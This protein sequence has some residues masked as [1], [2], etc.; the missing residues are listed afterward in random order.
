MTQKK[1]T[2]TIIGAGSLGSVLQQFFSTGP[3]R[4]QSVY[5]SKTGT[6]FTPKG[7][8]NLSASSP[9]SSGEIGDWIFI[10]TP[11]DLISEIAEQ[12]SRIEAP[13]NQK[14][15]IHCSGA[16]FS[17]ELRAVSSLGASVVAM[18]PIQSF[19]HGDSR[20]RLKGIFVTLEGDDKAIEQLTPVVEAM[21]AHPVPA[22][23]DQKRS[24]HI[25]AVMVSNYTVALMHAAES[26]LSESGLHEGM[27][28]LEPL[29]RQ[30]IRNIFEK[31]PSESLTGPVARGDLDT[32]STHLK[33]LSGSEA[34]S[35]Y[36]ILGLQA[37][38]LAGKSGMLNEDQ[39]KSLKQILKIPGHN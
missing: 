4:L 36:R 10:T 6:H 1:P 8:V 11:D 30:T 25:A 2:V 28:M 37:A 38:H 34:E 14:I 29:V 3:F 39:V 17:D 35:L 5:N 23:K 31:G 18:H 22:S 26:L 16:L 15:V 13:W 12:I 24:L 9:Q 20:E 33:S 21:G 32:V 7:E 27:S 19:R